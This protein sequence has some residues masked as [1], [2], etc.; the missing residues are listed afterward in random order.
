MEAEKS[1]TYFGIT[2]ANAIKLVELVTNKKWN[3]KHLDFTY[4]VD[5]LTKL[6]E[7]EWERYLVYNDVSEKELKS[8]KVEKLIARIPLY[9]NDKEKSHMRFELHIYSNGYIDYTNGSGCSMRF[10][11]PIE[12][13]KI[14]IDA[15]FK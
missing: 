15:G 13:Y 3:P 5:D 11:N 7:D 1:K 14:L 8:K 4:E 6:S 9:P 10:A 12:I 2:E